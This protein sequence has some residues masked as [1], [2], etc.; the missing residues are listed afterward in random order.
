MKRQ[1]H[2]VAAVGRSV[3]DVAES[4]RE[5]MEEAV[6]RGSGEARKWYQR[7]ADTASDWKERGQEQ[8]GHAREHVQEHAIMDTLIA[9]ATGFLVAR[10]IFRRW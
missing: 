2:R 3:S 1:H 7:A 8:I 10:L 4:A 5:S 9:L 6:Q